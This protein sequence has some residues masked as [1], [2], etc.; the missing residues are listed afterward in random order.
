MAYDIDTACGQNGAAIRIQ[1]TEDGPWL[2]VGVHN[3]FNDDLKKNFG[4]VP[5]KETFLNYI[6]PYYLEQKMALDK[7]INIALEQEEIEDIGLRSL[8]KYYAEVDYMPNR[9]FD[10]IDELLL[11]YVAIW[12]FSRDI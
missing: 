1:E 11:E 9:I 2:A 3:T 12:K 5:T 8:K 10:V 6:L 4:T 7:D